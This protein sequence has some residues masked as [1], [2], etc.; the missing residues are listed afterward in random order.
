VRLL[1]LLSGRNRLEL[2]TT[3]KDEA[4]SSSKEVVPYMEHV[5]KI[6]LMP[7]DGKLEGIRNYLPWSRRAMLLLKAKR[8]EGFVTGESIEPKDMSSNDWKT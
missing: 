7:N 4:P 8:L 6:E 2:L 1:L 5:Q 3:K